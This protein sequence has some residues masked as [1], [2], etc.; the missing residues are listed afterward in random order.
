M[1]LVNGIEYDKWTNEVLAF[2]NQIINRYHN[3]GEYIDSYNISFPVDNIVALENG[4]FCTKLQGYYGDSFSNHSSVFADRKFNV[5]KS[6]LPYESEKE[7]PLPI[8]TTKQ[9][10]G[11]ISVMMP[12]NDTI[13]NFRNDTLFPTYLLDFSTKKIDKKAMTDIHF[14]RSLP[15]DKD[16]LYSYTETSTHQFFNF[17]DGNFGNYIFRD[18]NSTHCIYGKYCSSNDLPNIFSSIYNTEFC[19]NDWFITILNPF[20]Y[21]KGY[22]KPNK[23]INAEDVAKLDSLKEDDNIVLILYKLKSF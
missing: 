19:Y 3:D 15:K 7:I 13:Y 8:H 20:S 11:S 4:Y 6:M 5:K 18:K 1:A 9:K 2:Q 12:A 14:F 17:K 21:H 16:Y 22:I 23:F 10:D